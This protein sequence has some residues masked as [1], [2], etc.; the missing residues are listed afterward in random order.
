MSAAGLC[1]MPP[2]L[3]ALV[4]GS[5]RAELSASASATHLMIVAHRGLSSPAAP[6]TLPAPVGRDLVLS[7]A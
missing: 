4:V 7:R 6:V 1:L 3:R 2:T 5:P